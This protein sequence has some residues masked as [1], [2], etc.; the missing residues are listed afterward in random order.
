MY[1]DPHVEQLQMTDYLPRH[2]CINKQTAH[3]ELLPLLKQTG[4]YL[5]ADA[6]L[7]KSVVCLLREKTMAKIVL[8]VHR[9]HIEQILHWSVYNLHRRLIVHQCNMGHQKL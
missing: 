5:W 3:V 8:N 1:C 2:I 7:Y 4:Q 9:F 6:F